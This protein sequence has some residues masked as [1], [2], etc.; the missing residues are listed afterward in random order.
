MNE[1][2]G[3][4]LLNHPLEEASAFTPDALLEAVR[5]EKNLPREPVPRVCLLDFDGDATDWLVASGRAARCASWACFHTPMWSIEIDGEPCGIVPRTIGGPYAVLVAEQ[6]AASGAKLILGLTSAGRVDPSLPLPSFVVATG[7]VRDE[8]SSLH[9]IAPGEFVAAPNAVIQPLCAGLEALG[10]KVSN[11]AVWTTDAPYRETRSQLA[12]HAEA[13]VLAVEM[14]AA[15]LFAFA[16][17]RGTQVGVVAQVTN[18]VDQTDEAF[19]KGTPIDEGR[20][21]E[22]ILRAGLRCLDLAA[23][24]GLA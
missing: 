20:V 7:A 15:S 8:G 13:G 18:A 6:L 9:Y 3:L 24:R 4:P 14:Q 10:R 19:D 23:A 16:A 2:S 17:A 5:V 22:A 1:T 11:G 21:V 12:M